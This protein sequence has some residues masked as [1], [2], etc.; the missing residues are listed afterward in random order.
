MPQALAAPPREH[1]ARSA[2]QPRTGPRRPCRLTPRG[3]SSSTAS[4]I[5]YSKRRPLLPFRAPPPGSTSPRQRPRVLSLLFRSHALMAAGARSCVRRPGQGMR[6]AS[7]LWRSR[8]PREPRRGGSVCCARR[9]RHGGATCCRRLSS[10]AG[11]CL[12]L[13][14]SVLA[15]L[16]LLLRSQQLP[17]PRPSAERRPLS[18]SRRRLQVL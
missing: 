14:A 13:L 3:S 12:P 4:M 15:Q 18:I 11:H 8:P 17:P 9:P 5:L 2:S 6:R 10:T 16:C 1:V 7:S